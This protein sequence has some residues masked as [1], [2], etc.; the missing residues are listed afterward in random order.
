VLEERLVNLNDYF[1]YSLYENV[2]RS[3]FERHKLMFSFM[4]TIKI[5]QG[6]NEIDDSEWRYL[7]TGPSG[8]V[9]IPKNPTEW[10]PDNNWPD[11]YR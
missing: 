1:T 9:T 8:D 2:C 5:L 11:V 4:L 3:L 7:L 6:K 10:M